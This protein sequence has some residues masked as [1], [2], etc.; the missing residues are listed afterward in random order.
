V[1][2]EPNCEDAYAALF[3]NYIESGSAELAMPV[4][5]QWLANNPNSANARVVQAAVLLQARQQDAA[6]KILLDLFEHEP[7]NSDVL[8]A[9]AAFYQRIG[10]TDEFVAKLEAE[11][12]RHPENRMAIEQLVAIY[13][14]QKRLP[15][16]TR[17]LDSAKSAVAGDPDLMYYVGA[18]YGR[19]GQ[20]QT[21]EQILQEIVDKNPTYA[22]ASNDLGYTWADRGENMSRAENLIRV[23]VKAEPD[24]QSYLDSLGWVLYK[25]GKFEEARQ[26]LDQ[27]IAPASYPDPVVLDHLGDALYRLGRHDDAVKQWKRS[28][29]R[30]TQ[31]ENSER[32]DLKQLRL[33]LQQKIRQADSGQPVNVAPIVET[34]SNPQPHAQK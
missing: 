6:Q 20:R 16:A 34:A 19:I 10:R 21:Q 31:M 4:L 27:A 14:Q 3:R 2:D 25:R 15:E 1:T 13:S 8:N 22:P 7:D 30:L 18:L 5:K 26:Y 23:A 12:T 11:R 32:D 9:V 33:Q 28:Q 29:Q 24:N 17:V